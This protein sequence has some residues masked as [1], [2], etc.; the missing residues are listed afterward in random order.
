MWSIM[1]FSSD[2]FYFLRVLESDIIGGSKGEAGN[3][4]IL[5]GRYKIVT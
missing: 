5:K 3:V 1:T 2:S 4:E